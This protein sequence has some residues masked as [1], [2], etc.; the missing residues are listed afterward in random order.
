MLNPSTA[1]ES[2]NDPTIRRCL[3]FARR[4]GYHECQAANLF[5]WVSSDPRDL[6]RLDIDPIGENDEHLHRLAVN[7]SRIVWAWGNW[8]KLGGRGDVGR[9]GRGGDGAFC[10]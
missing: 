10:C 9:M 4:W 5:A 6:C 7:A 2:M 1:D 3:G 8:G